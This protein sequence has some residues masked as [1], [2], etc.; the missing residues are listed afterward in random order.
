VDYNFRYAK[1]KL[2]SIAQ[3]ILFLIQILNWSMLYLVVIFQ[4][5]LTIKNQYSNLLFPQAFNLHILLYSIQN[6]EEV[7]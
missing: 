2:S 4:K 5:V 1:T 3:H 7:G 6:R